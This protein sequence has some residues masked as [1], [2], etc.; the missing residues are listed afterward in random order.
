MDMFLALVLGGNYLYMCKHGPPTPPLPSPVSSHVWAKQV[1]SRHSGAKTEHRCGRCSNQ[2]IQR[3]RPTKVGVTWATFLT[4]ITHRA[5]KLGKNALLYCTHKY[6][7][8]HTNIRS[9]TPFMCKVFSQS[10]L[11]TALTMSM[12]V[13]PTPGE[14][15]DGEEKQGLGNV[16]TKAFCL[17]R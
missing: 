3:A 17:P 16:Q 1:F 11:K 15:V 2:S 5:P 9:A 10:G 13:K 6:T 12:P 4:T 7:H 14:E 8:T